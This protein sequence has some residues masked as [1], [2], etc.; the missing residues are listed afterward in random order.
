MSNPKK[1]YEKI[2]DHDLPKSKKYA[3][4]H[5]KNLIIGDTS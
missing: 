2:Q 4:S 5:P 1:T 3:H